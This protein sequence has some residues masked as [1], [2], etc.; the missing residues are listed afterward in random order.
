M[1]AIYDTDN[2]NILIIFLTEK[3]STTKFFI[4]EAWLHLS[5]QSSNFHLQAAIAP[6]NWS[7][8]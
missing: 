8:N 2:N 7:H 1:K 3:I 4:W 6:H 5:H